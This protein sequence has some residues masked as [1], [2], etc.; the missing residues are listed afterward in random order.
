MKI[1]FFTDTYFPQLNGVATSVSYFAQILRNAGHQVHIIA[2]K[3]NGYVDKDKDVYRIPSVRVWPTVPDNVRVPLPTPNRSWLKI[4]RLDYDIIHAHGNGLFSL[5]GYGVAKQKKVPFI[6]TFHTLINQYGHYFLNGKVLTPEI[7]DAVLRIFA[8]ICD[9][10]VTPSQKMKLELTKMGVKKPITVIPNFVDLSR[11]NVEPDGF[12]HKMLKLPPKAKIV[13]SVGR[14][15]KEKNLKFIIEMF[16][17]LAKIDTDSHLV[18]VGEGVEEK[19]LQALI[20][21]FG[22][23]Q[24]AHLAGGISNDK[25]PYVYADSNI[26][27]FAS[28]SEVHPMVTIEAA[29]AG[30]PLV[31]IN[32]RAFDREIVDG[33][34]GFFLPSDQK[35]FAQKTKEILTNPS[36]AKEFGEY[37][38]QLVK[39]NFNEEVILAKI[40]KLYKQ[41]L[42][43]SS[44]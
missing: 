2:P 39:N 21:K 8:N 23:S 43:K 20:D 24:R 3:I 32:D 26:F 31:L 15:G 40:D 16:H 19:K 18:I 35:L 9:G 38:K 1:G 5:L 6:L 14:L 42:A 37:S 4:F 12:L 29:A 36:L 11:F 41:T 28:T 13:L 17:E 10:V 22:L 25:M 7:M 44:L 30:L 34:N 33:K 27:V